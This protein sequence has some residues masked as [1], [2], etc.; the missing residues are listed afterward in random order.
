V[1]ARTENNQIRYLFIVRKITVWHVQFQKKK[2]RLQLIVWIKTAALGVRLTKTK[3]NIQIFYSAF[4]FSRTTGVV[5]SFQ[6]SM[7]SDD[8][9]FSKQ[10]LM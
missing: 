7:M 9:V 4:S 3:P 8:I 2:N 5:F 6:S 1:H 10:Q